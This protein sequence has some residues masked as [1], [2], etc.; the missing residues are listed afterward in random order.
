MQNDTQLNELKSVLYKTQLLVQ[1]LAAENKQ[2]KE[3]RHSQ[4]AQLNTKWQKLLSETTDYEQLMSIIVRDIANQL[5]IFS[6][7]FLT[8][9]R[10]QDTL[11]LTARFP[12]GDNDHIKNTNI[13]LDTIPYSVQKF[14]KGLPAIFNSIEDIPKENIERKT[15]EKYHL[16]SMAALPINYNTELQGIITVNNG[17]L[18]KT[19]KDSDID[20]LSIAAPLLIEAYQL[21][22]RQ[23]FNDW[24]ELYQKQLLHTKSQETINNC[25]LDFCKLINIDSAI[26]AG[27]PENNQLIEVYSSFPPMLSIEEYDLR[28]I[29]TRFP[30]TT[31][32]LKN[33]KTAIVNTRES[34]QE[35]ALI[36]AKSL[37]YQQQQSTLS[38]PLIH[39]N[40]LL[41]ALILATKEKIHFWS[42]GEIEYSK[43]IIPLLFSAQQ[44]I[45]LKLAKQ[46]SMATLEF[47]LKSTEVSYWTVNK[48]LSTSHFSPLFYEMLE[49]PKNTTK[50]QNIL[51]LIFDK[52]EKDKE[53][54]IR[55]HVFSTG[56]PT[57][58]IF[59]FVTYAKKT[60]WIKCHYSPFSFN[61][62]NDVETI[63]IS[64]NDISHQIIKQQ[65]LET[66]RIEA[67]KANT[68]KGLFL[69]RMSHEIRTPMNAILGMAHLLQ[70]A[71]LK[72]NEKE[73]VTH[74]EQAAGNLL[75]II[76]DIL[77]FSK[78]ESGK[79]E[80]EKSA[81]DLRSILKEST[82][83]AL[84]QNLNK[85]VNIIIDVEQTIPDFLM[86]DA[87][88]LR[89]VLLNLLSN[90]IKFTP[91]GKISINISKKTGD[92]IEFSIKDQ[93]IGI[94]PDQ[95]KKLFK[96][97]SQADNSISRRYGGTGLG[98]SI[99]KS[100]IELMRGSL[101]VDS[102]VDKG[103]CF[104]F[105]LPLTPSDRKAEKL[106]QK[107]QNYQPT[108]HKLKGLKVLV[109]EDNIVN[110]KVVEGILKKVGAKVTFSSNGQ[111]AI[112]LLM[113]KKQ[114]VEIILMDIEMPLVDGYQASRYIRENLKIQTPI[115][116][117]TAHAMNSAKT[118]SLE[119]GMNAYVTKPIKPED[120]YKTLNRVLTSNQLK[121]T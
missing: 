27:L 101:K 18:V 75:A 92:L 102:T 33:N 73:K 85:D 7:N 2:L 37:S 47:V 95:I 81:F 71:N 111:E 20:L 108:F 67:D 68:E 97:Y 42:D 32:Q 48:D 106:L 118:K 56:E 61:D 46:A 103:S 3:Q 43:K 6:V 26:F 96:P 116:A 117:L 22:L 11:Q 49:I 113:A 21:H 109:A 78:I 44:R 72:T 62:N 65:E 9:N 39:K 53:K 38:I 104:T 121:P 45:K 57:T 115:I 41:G 14:N 59:K 36:D 120:L 84:H 31:E 54:K 83:I 100:L 64:L 66:S 55:N 15:I 114:H 10:E 63:I 58:E 34:L 86:G 40:Q 51:K 99:V 23:K 74:I 112:E 28:K 24:F 91:K 107:Q 17:S 119:A 1:Q 105:S 16:K 90:A 30:W 12:A 76:N 13:S 50:A 94:S 77:D 70:D 110:Q 80:L 35:I 25:L 60:K 29:K 88:R 19:W 5:Q 69:A 93:G 82:Q 98:L 52:P 8:Y 4:F 87:L 79:I 89:Q